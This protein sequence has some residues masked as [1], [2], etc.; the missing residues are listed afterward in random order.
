VK[1]ALAVA[2]VVAGVILYAHRSA[3]HE[4]VVDASLALASLAVLCAAAY[5]ATCVIGRLRPDP[6]RAAVRHRRAAAR[7][8]P[9]PQAGRPCACG[10]PA[11]SRIDGRPA[12]A[13]CAA[14][15]EAGSGPCGSCGSRPAVTGRPGGPPLCRPCAGKAAEAALAE[16]PGYRLTRPPAVPA[17]ETIGHIDMSEFERDLPS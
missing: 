10:G 1:R 8:A 11:T 2:A 9:R 17:G 3:V 15:W 6:A 12:C 14:D 13:E 7:P 16:A 5:A 4:A